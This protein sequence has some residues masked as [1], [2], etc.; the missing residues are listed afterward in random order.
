MRRY[1]TSAL[2]VDDVPADAERARA[3]LS[4]AGHTVV[5]VA[6][7][8]EA[9]SLL[10]VIRFSVLLVA[11]PPGMPD[12]G[13]ALAAIRDVSGP[14]PVVLCITQP[15]ERFA[16]YARRGFA[17][18]RCKPSEAGELLGTVHDI[19]ATMIADG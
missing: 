6:D 15:P 10:A 18:L 3:I 4:A 9:R 8:A 11:I 16:G 19:L 14:A 7:H 2:V 1:T 5:A 13:Q 12:P 17:G